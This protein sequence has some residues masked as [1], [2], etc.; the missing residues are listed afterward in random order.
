MLFS[1]N[2]L[3][4]WTHQIYELQLILS[5]FIKAI[6][7]DLSGEDDENQIRNVFHVS[8]PS[9]TEINNEDV[10]NLKIACS[11]Y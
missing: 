8:M 5:S 10:F 7:L 11:F 9:K 2:L 3:A 4:V 1:D 6:I